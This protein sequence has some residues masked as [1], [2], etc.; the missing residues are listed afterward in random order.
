MATEFKGMTEE[1]R[2]TTEYLELMAMVRSLCPALPEYL[3][4]MTVCLHKTFP[5]AYRDKSLKK[6][7]SHTQKH[8]AVKQ[9]VYNTIKVF[10][11]GVKDADAAALPGV[12]E[13]AE[14]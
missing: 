10:D 13:P 11:H 2:A 7:D 6:L 12:Q 14:A 1:Y 3:A 9:T 5:N 4:E 8:E